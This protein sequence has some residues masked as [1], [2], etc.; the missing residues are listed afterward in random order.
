MA[1]VITT[2]VKD[3]LDGSTEGVEPRSFALD[4]M[5][6][7][8]DLSDHNYGKLVRAL[9]PFTEKAR[10]GVREAPRQSKP[11][12]QSKREESARVRSWAK[13]AGLEVQDKGRIPG[14]VLTQYEAAHAA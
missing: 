3:D 12:P 11:R 2:T 8:I 9:E 4:G 13:A 14:Y 6:Y 7:V 5:Q 10:H 1:T